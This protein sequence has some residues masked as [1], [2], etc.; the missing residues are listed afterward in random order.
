MVVEIKQIGIDYFGR[1][2]F[3]TKQGSYVVL[4]DNDF[5]SKM[6]NEPEGEPYSKLKKDCLKVVQEFS[7]NNNDES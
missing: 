3:I 4:V 6:P 7:N 1:E 2:L 5:Y